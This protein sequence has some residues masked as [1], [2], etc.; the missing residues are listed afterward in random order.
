MAKAATGTKSSGG[1]KAVAKTSSGSHSGGSSG[2]SSGNS[3]SGSTAGEAFIK[4]LQSPLVADLLAVAATAALALPASDP[5]DLIF[6]D[7]PYA[8]GSGTAAVEAVERAGWLAPGGWMSVE[9][10]RADEV[11]ASGLEIQTSRIVG[12]ARLTLLRRP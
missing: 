10:S 9:T 6:A 4:L 11:A 7:P 12:R 2:N 5:F 8:D 1:S 3:S